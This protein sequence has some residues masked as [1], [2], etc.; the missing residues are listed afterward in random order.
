MS[1]DERAI[2]SLIDAWLSA[3][4]AGDLSKVLSLMSE[5]VL[6]MVPGREPFG[7]KEFA[8]Q[9]QGMKDVDIAGVSDVKEVVVVGD[10]AYARTH[11]TVTVTPPGGQPVVRAGYTLSVL[12]RQA[13]G[14]VIARDANLL[15]SQ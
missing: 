13:G 15:V 11:L 14:W 8:E 9:A 4:R 7:K 10:L 6:F 12:R 5:D 3:S 1:E 2:R